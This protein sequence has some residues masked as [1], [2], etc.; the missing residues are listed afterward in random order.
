[1]CTGPAHEFRRGAH[2]AKRTQ[3]HLR[4]AGLPKEFRRGYPAE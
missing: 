2:Y 3:S 1:M 4:T